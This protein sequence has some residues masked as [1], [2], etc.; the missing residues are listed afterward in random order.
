MRPGRDHTLGKEARRDR[1]AR[2]APLRVL[3]IAIAAAATTALA[4]GGDAFWVCV[5][6]AL[7]AAATSR[8]RR[9]GAIGAGVVV[10][11]TAGAA[12]VGPRPLPSPALIVV[13]PAASVAIALNIRMRLEHERDALRASAFSDPLTGVANRRSLLERIDYEIARHARNRGSFT[14]LMLDLDGFKALNDR[15]GHPAGDDLL[16]DVAAALSRV[17]RDQDTLARVGGDE[18]CV[19]AP[20][21]D[22]AGAERL[23]SRVESA[24]SRVVAGIEALGAGVGA[25]VFPH[26]GRTA[27]ALLQAADQRLLEAKRHTRSARRRARAA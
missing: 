1:A 15:F 26:D 21:T 18:F 20:E 12:L 23:T 7:M 14:L 19:L 8:G 17:I 4:G 16:C 3:A 24:V 2:R 6:A 11:T 22:S 9:G 5:P 10:A 25:G 27:D 13:I